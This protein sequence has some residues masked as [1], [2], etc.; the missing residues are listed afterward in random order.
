MRYCTRTIHT[1]PRPH[2]TKEDEAGEVGSIH[3]TVSTGTIPEQAIPLFPP[4]TSQENK[5]RKK[6]EKRNH[7][8]RNPQPRTSAVSKIPEADHSPKRNLSNFRN[9]T[10]TMLAIRTPLRCN[11][12]NMMQ[13][14][15]TASFRDR[16]SQFK[17][18]AIPVQFLARGPRGS[19]DM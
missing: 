18:S 2:K 16:V 3:S 17:T 13:P 5:K 6:K 4:S 9:L 14:H 8:I 7:T 15:K 1:L 12:G 11:T 19:F 10:H